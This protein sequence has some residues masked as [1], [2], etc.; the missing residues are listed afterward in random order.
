MHLSDQDLKNYLSGDDSNPEVI[1]IG[2]HLAECTLCQD[3]VEKFSRAGVETSEQMSI[4][5]PVGEESALPITRARMRFEREY[6]EKEQTKMFGRI[7]LRKYRFAWAAAAVVILLSVAM[8][9]P[10]VRAIGSSFLGLFRVEQFTIVQVDPENIEEQLGSSSNFEYLLAE[11]VQFEEYGEMQEIFSK[12]EAAG[13]AGFEVRLP[14]PAPGDQQLIVQPGGRVSLLV[15]LPKVQA[16]LDELRI[17]ELR[18]PA[19]LDGVEVSLDLPVAVAAA[20]GTCEVTP[21]IMREAGEDPD[22]RP[23]VDLSECVTLTQFP[24]PEISAPPGLDIARIGQAFLQV[25]GMTPEEA[26]QFSQ[27]VDWTTT[28][29]IPVPR[30]GT[31]YQEVSVDGVEG[32]LIMQ[33]GRSELRHYLLVWIKN[34]IVYALAGPG[35]AQS[36]VE[37]ANTI[38]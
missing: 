26:A 35:D 24:S 22:R 18:L 16:L 7:F 6:V 2:N 9:I 11:D 33:S 1:R 34:G 21:E 13:L 23:M 10:Q 28:L 4:L 19:E 5:A 31:E 25:L 32:T 12:E 14:A 37:L 17:T 30:Y 36:A 29:V 27:T 20:Y 3:R 8:L 15:D 38:E